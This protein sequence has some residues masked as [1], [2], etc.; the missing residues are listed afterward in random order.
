MS[1]STRAVALLL[2]ALNL[3]ITVAPH[4]E[5]SE[6]GFTFPGEATIRS[7]D[8]GSHEIHKDLKD[9][10]E[11]LLCSRTVLFVAFVVTSLVPSDD[12]VGF[13][14]APPA[15][16]PAFCETRIPFLLRGPPTQVS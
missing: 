5:L 6:E 4:I 7:H 3:A 14:V 12:T 13:F 1:F 16:E 15:R 9:H 10:G 2:V 8:C 11:C